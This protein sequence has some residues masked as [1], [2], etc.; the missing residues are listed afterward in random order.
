MEGSKRKDPAHQRL[1]VGSPDPLSD[2]YRAT[3]RLGAIHVAHER[4]FE[5]VSPLSGP[6][7]RGVLHGT[8]WHRTLDRICSA[9]T[10]TTGRTD[11]LAI[12]SLHTADSPVNRADF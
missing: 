9:D 6:R 10:R 8:V 7:H 4:V 12:P 3:R 11:H 5:D 1:F 2:G